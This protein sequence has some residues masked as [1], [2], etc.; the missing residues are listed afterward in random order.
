REPPARAEPA[1]AAPPPPAEPPSSDSSEAPAPTIT[2]SS[3][4]GAAAA[5][6]PRWSPTSSDSSA[7]DLESSTGDDSPP[8]KA[9]PPRKRSRASFRVLASNS[10]SDVE[11]VDEIFVVD[12]K[13]ETDTDRFSIGERRVYDLKR[14]G[15]IGDDPWLLRSHRTGGDRAALEIEGAAVAFVIEAE[16]G[17]RLL[18]GEG[19]RVQIE[20]VKVPKSG[21][22]LV[23]GMVFEVGGRPYLYFDRAANEA[24]R[25]RVFVVE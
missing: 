1:K 25:R 14:D 3:A 8:K 4:D 16:T 7:P 22:A 24:E 12:D 19:A 10:I 9:A 21:V 2:T 5:P 17:A 18:P 15:R 11:S 13:E 23:H 20:S 6:S